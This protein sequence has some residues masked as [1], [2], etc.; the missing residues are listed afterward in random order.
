MN[1]KKAI[2]VIL[3]ATLLAFI[4]VLFFTKNDSSK[5][6]LIPNEPNESIEHQIFDKNTIKKQEENPNAEQPS[7]NNLPEISKPQPV[8]KQIQT[9]TKPIT[10][11]TIPTQTTPII[12]PLQVEET[13]VEEQ[14]NSTTLTDTGVIKEIETNEI[15]I[16]K[17]YKSPTPAKYSF[18]GFGVQKAPTK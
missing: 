14:K 6:I 5:P 3:L 12:K 10:K 7:K 13:K 16:M 18:E 4:T 2:I 15:V 8:N 17:E 9:P 1:N 11:Q